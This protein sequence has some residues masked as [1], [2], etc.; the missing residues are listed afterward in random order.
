MI[1][2]PS[3]ADGL[4][5]GKPL[6]KMGFCWSDI[7]TEIFFDYV[8]VPK[9]NRIATPGED[10]KILHNSIAGGRVGSASYAIGGA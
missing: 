5:F 8:R 2:I 10:A 1:Y 7:N 9:E 6:E 4:S 3:D